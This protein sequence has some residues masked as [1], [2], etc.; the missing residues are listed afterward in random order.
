MSISKIFDF[1]L[2][3]QAGKRLRLGNLLQDSIALIVSEIANEHT[4]VMLVITADTLTAN[5]LEAALTFFSPELLVYNFPDWE[6]LPYDH[7]SPHQDIISQRLLTLTQLPYVKRGLLLVPM[8]TL[9]QRLAP[10]SYIQSTGL[11]IRCGERRSIDVMRQGLQKAGYHS[12]SQVITRGE[13]A[14]RG[15]LLDI[16]PMGCD[17]PYRLDFL[18]DQI[19]SIRQF[20]PETQR[21]TQKLERINLLP[22]REFPLSETAI[23]LFRQQ[24][25]ENFSGN[26]LNCPI[27]EAISHAY[28]PA[29]IEYYLPLFFSQTQLLVDYLPENTLIVEINAI[30]QAAECFWQEINERYEQLRHNIERPLLAP[31]QL[32]V[33]LDELFAKLKQFPRI[34]LQQ[35][36]LQGDSERYNFPVKTF[37]DLTIDH[38]SEQPVAKVENFLK[39]FLIE[40]DA[41]VL[42]CVESAGRREVL[43]GLIKNLM[44]QPTQCKTWDEFLHASESI[45]IAITPLEEGFYFS[46]PAYA[47][48]TESQLLGHHVIQQ[49]QKRGKSL[50]SQAIIRNLAELHLGSPVVHSDH[51]IGRYR[52]LQHLNVGD[53]ESEYM[54][55]EYADNAMLY[56]PIASLDLISR[57]SGS[58]SEHAPLHRLGSDQWKK[59]KQKAAE[60]MRDV[61][62]E[63][64]DVYAR[65]EAQKGYSF[66]P[67]DEN[68]R[69]FAEQFAF[70]ETPDQEQ[71]IKHVISD[72]ISD[73]PMDRLICGEP[74][75]GKTEVATRATFLAIQSNKQVVIL[76]P[77][78]LLAQQHYQ[79]FIDRFSEWPVQIDMLSRFRSAAEQKMIQQRLRLGHI[80]ILIG[81]HKLLSKEL[82]FT[83]LGLL[84]IDEEHRFGVQQKERLKSLR[85]KIDILSLTATPIP[86]TLH[87][88]FSGLRELSIIATPPARRL[89]IKT[90]IQLRNTTL[91]RETILRELLRG[92]QVYFL[93]NKVQTI[94]KTAQDLA[95][96]V[97]EAR[98]QIAH[99]QL[100]ERELE[101]I[102]AD[103][104]HQ[105]FNVLVC[106]TIIETG[107]DIP[108]ANTIIIDRADQFGLAQLHQLRGR[109]GR[110]HHQAYAYLMVPPKEAMTTDAMKRLDALSTL[111]DLGAGF[112]LATHD[113]EIRGAGEL[114]GERQSG[115]MQCI[116]F[117]LYME[118]LEQTIKA[119]KSDQRLTTPAIVSE[120][121]TEIDL[122]ISA[123]IP[124]SY[125]PDVH[126]RL[127]LYKRLASADNTKELEAL[128]VEMIDRFGLFPNPI[129]NLFQV[130]ELKLLAK[131]LGIKKI[132]MG[133]QHGLIEFTDKPTI[134]PLAIIQ[135]I[136]KNPK[137]YKLDGPSRLRFQL[138]EQNTE[139]RIKNMFV[140][141]DSFR[142]KDDK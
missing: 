72:M 42:F 96:L 85:S 118:L 109:V 5:R 40:K 6:T 105:R 2:P 103:F 23:N 74:G 51:G 41:K 78:T 106:T 116:G 135:L 136:Q 3:A 1:S 115:N 100:H 92:G 102:M 99:G 27:Y 13:Y 138:E 110:S 125:I 79:T 130:T 43:L 98:I 24:W 68:Y 14:V 91:I 10:L 121:N 142:H 61:A 20:D 83:R 60:Q 75:F 17:A 18:D 12:V 73:K 25:R 139:L 21:S 66:N 88:A 124:E 131:K 127:V 9:M 44:I 54:V 49:R 137:Q 47:L 38:K 52:G 108:S 16:F 15:S 76:V 81:T 87:M 122:Q 19:D 120:Q 82:Q 55:L 67:P 58:T 45:C 39:E 94:A 90:F 113:L 117:S 93:H 132:S 29:G 104:Y 111:E 80:D 126:T 22:A 37:P 59:A 64:L 63:L 57:Y 31:P 70:T 32:Y 141:L 84:I 77:T 129:K 11:V 8:T 134:N 71:A 46:H 28:V 128:Q 36:P 89:S 101:R 123:L 35:S 133:T 34:L 50:D 86:R 65:R 26:P 62:A 112:T 56:V 4:G 95:Q 69:I 107:I 119:L 114:L 48:I 7:F 140:L 30:H 97:P 33:V 53:Q